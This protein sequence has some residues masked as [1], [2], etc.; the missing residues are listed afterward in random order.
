M[1]EYGKNNK[2][3]ERKSSRNKFYSIK[4]RYKMLND[5][6]CKLR[7]ELNN[8]ILNGEDYEKI[9]EISVNLDK[10]IAEYYKINEQKSDI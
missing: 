10:L 2:K 6:I 7:E 4:G 5:E 9:L 8:S 1:Q 3:C